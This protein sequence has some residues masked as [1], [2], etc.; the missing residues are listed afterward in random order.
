MRRHHFLKRVLTASLAAGLCCG[1]IPAIANEADDGAAAMGRYLETEVELPQS[2]AGWSIRGVART[3]QGTLRMLAENMDDDGM[4]GSISILDSSDGGEN[5]NLTAKFP[6]EDREIYFDKMALRPDGSGVAAGMVFS[7]E[8]GGLEI[9]DQDTYTSSSAEGIQVFSDGEG[10]SSDDAVM[11]VNSNFGVE[12]CCVFFDADGNTM[13]RFPL[14]EGVSQ[15]CFTEDGEVLARTY[16][17]GIYSIDQETGEMTEKFMGSGAWQIAVCQDRLLVLTSSEVRWYDISTQEPLGRDESME[18]VLFATGKN[19][20]DTSSEGQSIVFTQDEE[21]RLYFCTNGGIYS[22]SLDGS[23]VEQVVDG[24]MTSLSDPE[25]SLLEMAVVEGSFYVTYQNE[26]DGKLLKYTYD[27][28]IAST[29]Q[30]EITVYSLKEDKGLRQAIVTYQ[31]LHPDTYVNYEVGLT[32]A[33][34]VTVSDALRTLNTDI[35]AGNGPDV[36]V[37]DGMSVSTYAGKGLLQDLSPVLDEVREN[38]GLLDNIAETWKNEDGIMAVPIRFGLTLASG[39]A[40][41]LNR[42]E[43]IASLVELSKEE[44]ALDYEEILQLPEILYY[45]C[46]NE[47]K[48]E[49]GTINQEKLEDYVQAVKQITDNFMENASDQ[50][51]KMLEDFKE[52]GITDSYSGEL[53]GMNMEF[54]LGKSKMNFGVLLDSMNYCGLISANKKMGESTVKLFGDDHTGVYLPICTVGILDTVREPEE[55]REFVK[56][57]LSKEGELAA[58]YSGFPVNRAALDKKLAHMDVGDDAGMEVAGEF[59]GYYMDTGESV[60]LS[61]TWPEEEEQQWL[62]NAAESLTAFADTEQ[63]PRQVVLEETRRCVNGEISTQEAVNSIMQKLNLYL[64]ESG[65]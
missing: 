3:D 37:L 63:I 14:K 11:M 42:L 58:N 32:G 57:L 16:G 62:K 61:Y 45:L 46:S 64:A 27:P 34:G 22:H 39:K 33:D 12:Y 31:K 19:Y 44:G 54:L 28:N 43:N 17:G 1:A 41:V 51:L 53:D 30:K 23:V 2:E 38:D 65:S 24:T 55:A 59:T 10:E 56:Y 25:L 15:L 8:N 52:E 60:S 7:E 47:W 21:G 6:E 35:L 48:N 18:N 36:L 26:T 9:G 20:D 29:P 4:Y 40:E 50:T 49:D 13:H 5:W